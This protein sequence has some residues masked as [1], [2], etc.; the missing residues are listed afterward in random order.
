[1]RR[2]FLVFG[3]GALLCGGVGR[4]QQ[5]GGGKIGYL[6]PRTIAPDAPTLVVLRPAWEKLGYSEPGSVILRSA[7]GD[8]ARLPELVRDLTRAGA[9]VIIA[10][11][12]AAVKAAREAG[13]VAVVAIDQ[14]TDP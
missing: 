2:R 4:A 13:T 9:G 3:A 5:T 1:M 12:P 6:H 10:V 7:D 8:P 11:G 14:E